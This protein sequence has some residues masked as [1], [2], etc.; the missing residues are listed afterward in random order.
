M[1]LT[2]KDKL[3]ERMDSQADVAGA[4]LSLIRNARKKALMKFIMALDEFIEVVDR[5]RID[6][7]D[8][9][10]QE[11]RTTIEMLSEKLAEVEC[12][13]VRSLERMEACEG[14][15]DVMEMANDKD[16]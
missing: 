12:D 4:K 8:T 14:E 1:Y 3:A 13:A 6:G 2:S 15:F 9:S 11:R 10:E 7:K 5:E 16:R